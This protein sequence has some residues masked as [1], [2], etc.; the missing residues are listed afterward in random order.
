M[1][2]NEHNLRKKSS[3]VPHLQIIAKITQFFEKQAKTCFKIVA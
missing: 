2:L 1:C 3:L